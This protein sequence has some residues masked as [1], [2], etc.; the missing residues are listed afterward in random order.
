MKMLIFLIF[1]TFIAFTISANLDSVNV[2]F[3]Y[4][5]FMKFRSQ[6]T[7]LNIKCPTRYQ[8]T[9]CTCIQCLITN[10]SVV[11][12]ESIVDNKN[13]LWATMF[14]DPDSNERGVYAFYEGS[15]IVRISEFYSKYLATIQ[16]TLIFEKGRIYIPIILEYIFP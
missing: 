16:Q 1:S 12:V 14:L 8:N 5:N 10:T 15:Y 3:V 4:P 9:N 13:L 6:S 11:M 7:S 2:T